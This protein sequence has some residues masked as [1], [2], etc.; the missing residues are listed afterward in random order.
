MSSSLVVRSSSRRK[1][2]APTPITSETTSTVTAATAASKSSNGVVN[3]ADSDAALAAEL[4]ASEA[5]RSYSLRRRAP[6]ASTSAAATPVKVQ[7]RMV[8]TSAKRERA[9]SSPSSASEDD[10]AA[11]DFSDHDAAAS[12]SDHDSDVF[13]AE[14]SSK[15][16]SKAKAT[17]ATTK[18]TRKTAVK[19]ESDDETNPSPRKRTAPK[20]TPKKPSASPFDV[21]P[22]K[23]TRK[24][25][26]VNL[27]PHEAHPAPGNWELVYTLL[28][29]Q[30]RKIVAP[31]D[32]MGCE[33]NG[34][35][36][37]RADSWRATESP[38]EAAKRERLATLVSL[39]LSSQTKDPVT[40]EAVYN[41]QR[42][43]PNGLCLQSLLEA[44]DEVISGCIA[45]VGFWRRKTGYLKSAARILESDFDGD[46][47][48]T[49][50]ELCSLP[51]VG[52]KM[53]F[54]ALSSMGI[55][56]GIG[57]DTHVHRLTNRLG[58]HTTKTPEETRLNLQS[59]LPTELH[60]K[61]NRLLVGFGQVICV[62]VGPRCDLCA[63]GQAGLCP[64]A[65][66]VDEK[67]TVKRVK[68]ELLASDDEGVT[69]ED[70][71]VKV[72]REEGEARVKVEVDGMEVANLA[73]PVTVKKEEVDKDAVSVERALEW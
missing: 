39:M 30:R 40:A 2:F 33:E 60:G 20:T 65:R 48:K 29:K 22:R 64:S 27:E 15:V 36:D 12:S 28:S 24:P 19:Q 50:D 73:R 56:L 21:S 43:L 11:S 16:K 7:K 55:Q 45:K 69:V 47:P 37:R 35:Q 72:K 54:L 52:P 46:V 3:G 9:P 61:I 4:S 66:E 5:R 58:W 26:K 25:I 70:N 31:V 23:P 57:V 44:S 34:R 17:K 13:S 63:V 38:L 59:W 42:T 41:L 49:V 51:G 67:S 68:V 1:L 53:A 10:S 18:R 62:P 6:S 71:W 32:T 8:R 14:P